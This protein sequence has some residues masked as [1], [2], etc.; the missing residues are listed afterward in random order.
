MSLAVAATLR[1]SGIIARAVFWIVAVAL[2]ASFVHK[3]IYAATDGQHVVP[4]APHAAVAAPSSASTAAAAASRGAIRG[5]D[6]V[7][8]RAVAARSPGERPSRRRSMRSRDSV[9]CSGLG[10]SGNNC[11]RGEVAAVV[12]KMPKAGGATFVRTL[13]AWNRDAPKPARINWSEQWSCS[14][15]PRFLLLREPTEHVM[16]MRDPA[17][18]RNVSTYLQCLPS[19]VEGKNPGSVDQVTC[20]GRP[21]ILENDLDLTEL[22]SL[23]VSRVESVVGFDAGT[24]TAS[25]GK[26]C[27]STDTNA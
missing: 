20:I 18:N 12:H 5:T 27:R 21:R 8:G 16:S 15:G 25:V 13:I 7:S 26:A 10:N 6:R 19:Y 23:E 2:C 24:I 3:S 4:L 14:V 11:M 22:E 9:R 17:S 1:R